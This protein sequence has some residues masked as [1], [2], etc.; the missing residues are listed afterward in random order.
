MSEKPEL[1]L[2]VL[3]E[4]DEKGYKTGFPDGYGNYRNVPHITPLW[5]ECGK[6]FITVEPVYTEVTDGYSWLFSDVVAVRIK[7]ETFLPRR[8][9]ERL[10]KTISSFGIPEAASDRVIQNRVAKTIEAFNSETLKV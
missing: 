3:K 8:G 1:V 7:V 9:R 10:L 4:L 6:K 2:R 5:L